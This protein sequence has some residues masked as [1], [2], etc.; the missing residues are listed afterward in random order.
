MLVLA[1]TAALVGRPRVTLDN[2]AGSKYT[3]QLYQKQNPLEKG[4][5]ATRGV[6]PSY[7]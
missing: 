1:V 2:R 3:A 4:F 6:L 7:Y 5:L